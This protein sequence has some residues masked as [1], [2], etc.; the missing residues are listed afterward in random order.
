M[1]RVGCREG[2]ASIRRKFEGAAWVKLASEGSLRVG[3]FSF[4]VTGC[5]F[6]GES[7]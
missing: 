5:V 4:L 1:A 6:D 3:N 7:L 2:E